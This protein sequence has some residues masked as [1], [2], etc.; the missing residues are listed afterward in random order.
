MMTTAT[1]KYKN[2]YHLFAI[3]SAICLVGPLLVF[4]IIGFVGAEVVGKVVLSMTALGSIILAIVSILF[5]Y[6]L[7][8]PMFVLLIGLWAVLEHLLPPMI[9]IS[10]TVILDEFIFSPLK[11]K[12]K[13]LYTINKEI[14]KR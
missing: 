7:R 9:I 13:N 2:L 3:L 6:H 1:K 14:D 12:Y 4:F 5:K 8:S 11:K 10:I